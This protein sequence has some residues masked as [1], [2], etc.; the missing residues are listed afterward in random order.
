[1]SPPSARHGAARVTRGSPSIYPPLI[2]LRIDGVACALRRQRSTSIQGKRNEC[3]AQAD[4]CSD[5]FRWS[6][7]NSTKEFTKRVRNRSFG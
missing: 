5:A 3:A 4:A 7:A 1:M 6:I 2:G